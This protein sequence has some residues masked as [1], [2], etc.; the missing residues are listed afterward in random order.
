MDL[1]DNGSLTDGIYTNWL[2]Y[3]WKSFFNNNFRFIKKDVL[4]KAKPRAQLQFAFHLIQIW[5]VYFEL[6]YD[7][8]YSNHDNEA[9]HPSTALKPITVIKEFW[10]KITPELYALFKHSQKVISFLHELGVNLCLFKSNIY[11]LIHLS[12]RLLP[13]PFRLLVRLFIYSFIHWWKFL[14]SFQIKLEAVPLFSQVIESISRHCPKTFAQVCTLL[15]F[16]L[17]Y[18]F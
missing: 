8:D 6:H 12:I 2:S 10:S 16:Y 5:N 18:P 3:N 14:F 13:Q 9:V 1:S 17:L 4:K 15:F 11:H 7:N